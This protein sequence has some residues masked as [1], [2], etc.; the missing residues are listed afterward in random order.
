[1]NV[2]PLDPAAR[3]WLAKQILDGAEAVI[4]ADYRPDGRR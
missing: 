3:E 1:M 4:R 2:L